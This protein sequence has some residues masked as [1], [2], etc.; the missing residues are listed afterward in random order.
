MKFASGAAVNAVIPEVDPYNPLGLPPFTIRCMFASGYTPSMGNT[1]TLVDPNRNIWDIGKNDQYNWSYLFN[2]NISLLEVLG[3]NTTG[4]DD[5]G[6]MF[7]GCTNLTSVALF[8]LRDNRSFGNMFNGCTS[9]TRVPL[10]DSDNV[11]WAHYMFYNCTSLVEVPQ[12]TLANAYYIES[13]FEGCLN[14]ESGAL[15]LYN[16]LSEDPDRHWQSHARCFNNCGAATVT[17]AAE[18]AQIPSDWK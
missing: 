10:F 1:Q 8:D 14:V 18:L 2:G 16:R 17:G 9:L 12:F 13:M 7:N 15:D 4:V 6:L 3:A 5:C 11:N